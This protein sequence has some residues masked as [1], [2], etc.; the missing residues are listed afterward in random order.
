MT[1]LIKHQLLHQ[2]IAKRNISSLTQVKS[3]IPFKP[4]CVV[5]RSISSKYHEPSIV[6]PVVN[7]L[8]FFSLC[9]LVHPIIICIYISFF[10]I[11]CRSF[12][13]LFSSFIRKICPVYFIHFCF[14]L[15]S[16]FV[17]ML[18]R[19]HGLFETTWCFLLHFHH[20]YVEYPCVIHTI[21]F[22]SIKSIFYITLT[23]WKLRFFF[24]FSETK[25]RAYIRSGGIKPNRWLKPPPLAANYCK[26]GYHPS[27]SRYNSKRFLP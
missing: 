24:F 13:F 21:L 18:Y 6:I 15:S 17:H 16:L 11:L 10:C 4:R 8:S 5:F 7:F 23:Q 27:I 3:T 25:A 22:A 20:T 1:L 14:R 9:F 12:F 19:L 2:S 26:N